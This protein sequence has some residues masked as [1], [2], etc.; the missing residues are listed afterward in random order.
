MV[1]VVFD[2]REMN[3]VSFIKDYLRC[4][5]STCWFLARGGGGGRCVGVVARFMQWPTTCFLSVFKQT[6]KMSK[7]HYLPLNGA[8]FACETFSCRT[9]ASTVSRG[10]SKLSCS[11][12]LIFVS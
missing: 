9:H 10:Y 4:D 3:F 12:Q 1:F 6:F 2:K 8:A 5:M 7:I 11:G